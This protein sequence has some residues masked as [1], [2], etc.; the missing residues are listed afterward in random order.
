MSRR[1]TVTV[2]VEV[3]ARGRP[4]TAGATARRRLAP[5]S[6]EGTRNDTTPSASCSPTPTTDHAAGPTLDRSSTGRPARAS[7]NRARATAPPP[8]ATD[9]GA[10][11][12]P[13]S[14]TVG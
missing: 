3:T 13:P 11:N 2:A 9:L 7:W 5:S 6:R 4:R 10:V 12:V 1:D 14:R 8:R